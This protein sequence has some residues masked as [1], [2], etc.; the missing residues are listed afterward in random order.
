MASA[1]IFE[2]TKK[3]N[4]ETQER[5]DL[6]TQHERRNF[7]G[8]VTAG[9][10][11][12]AIGVGF[13][14]RELHLDIPRWL[15]TWQMFLIAIGLY[16]GARHSFRNPGWIFPVGIGTLFLLKEYFVDIPIGQYWPIAIIIVGLFMIFKPRNKNKNQYWKQWDKNFSSPETSSEDFMDSVSIFGSLKKNIITKDFRGG[17]AVLIFSGA[18]LN[19]SQADINGKVVVE[20]TQM[21]AGSKLIVPAHWTIHTDDMV[22]IFGGV[23]D[24]R[25]FRQDATNDASKILVL[26]GTCIFGGIDIKSF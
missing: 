10:I 15:L 26:K 8:K 20:L 18:E 5:K 24:K 16:L 23:E 12:V 3:I 7:S 25:T 1:R 21:F 2:H 4:M 19:L 9:V 14:L 13:M 6:T 17:E 22:C 11:V